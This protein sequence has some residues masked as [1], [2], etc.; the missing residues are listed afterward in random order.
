[1][2]VD[3]WGEIVAAETA[4]KEAVVT[5]RIDFEAIH[6]VRSLIPCRRRPDLYGDLE[7]GE[8]AGGHD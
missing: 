3:P 2:I 1:M 7:P 6:R 5:E 8:R 4:E